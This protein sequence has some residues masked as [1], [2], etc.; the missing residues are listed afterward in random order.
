MNHLFRSLI[1]LFVFS[2]LFT[3]CDKEKEGVPSYIHITKFTLST[4]TGQGHN[5]SDITSAK[6]FV[7]GQ[8]IGN[9][10]LPATFPVLAEGTVKVEV[11]PNVKENGQSSSQKYYKPYNGDTFQVVLSKREIDT[12]RPSTTYRAATQFLWIE[13]FEDQTISL[14]KSGG[15]NTN[16]SFRL[17]PTSTPGVDQPFSGSA[18]CGSVKVSTDSFAV[19]ERSS[20]NVFSLPNLGTDNYIEM[21]IKSNVNFQIGIYTDDGIEVLQVPV[22]VAFPTGDKWKKIYINLKSETGTL[23]AGTKVRVFFGFYKEDND[24]QDKYV[25]IDNIKLLY[26]N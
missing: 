14:I 25:Y 20:F 12:I 18:Y 16:D 7:N 8:E 13:D 24:S 15:N 6:V 23:T 9:F 1:S 11:F 19:F 10:E 3:S 2:A 17:L 4:G 26:V 21:D 22:M 5:S